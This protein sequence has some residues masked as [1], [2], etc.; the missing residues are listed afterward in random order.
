MDSW[1]K[2]LNSKGIRITAMR[3]AVMETIRKTKKAL[4]PLQIFDLT[5][6]D[7]PHLGLVTVYRTIELLEREGLIEQIHHFE[8]CQGIL[9]AGEGHQH[10]LL[11]VKCGNAIH[12]DGIDLSNL[13]H[14]ISQETGF[15]IKEH[16]MQ[17]SGIC[18][19]CKT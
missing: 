10:V 15:Q 5:R 17:L 9:P 3:L 13:F 1:V 19:E 18:P 11:C 14:T 4:S 6:Q 12:F 8:N 7:H 16:W 2:K